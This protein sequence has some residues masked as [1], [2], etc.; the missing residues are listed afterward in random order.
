MDV[1]G[2]EGVSGDLLKQAERYL[3]IFHVRVLKEQ[4]CLA[5][6][7]ELVILGQEAAST[8]IGP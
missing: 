5:A 6:E 8:G 7:A 3:W 4:S 2:V 1:C